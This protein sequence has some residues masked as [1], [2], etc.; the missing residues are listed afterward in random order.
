MNNYASSTMNE[1]NA[2]TRP[3]SAR[4]GSRF[5]P[6]IRN[7]EHAEPWD[8]ISDEHR[9]EINDCVSCPF[10][11]GREHN[12]LTATYLRSSTSST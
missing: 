4:P 7:P 1:Y 6:P 12:R 9:N 2:S 10:P 8:Q 3:G 11:R 5:A